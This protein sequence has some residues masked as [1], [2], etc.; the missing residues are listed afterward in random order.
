MRYQ[1]L[2]PDYYDRR[3]TR[4]KI[5]YHVREI[6]A[7][8]LEVTLCR[9]PGPTGPGEDPGPTQTAPPAHPKSDGTTRRR[10]LPHAQL[11]SYFRARGWATPLRL[12]GHGH[13][14][15][16]EGAELGRR[17]D[18]QTARLSHVFGFETLPYRGGSQM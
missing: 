15:G 2:G 10:M 4:R 3:A 1:D 13:Y 7:L 18:G 16:M 8:G 5:D 17:L 6:E 14:L 11:R 12:A 9:K